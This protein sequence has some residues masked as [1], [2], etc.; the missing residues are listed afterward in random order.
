M[1]CH[2]MRT[3]HAPLKTLGIDTHQDRDQLA[4]LNENVQL[5]FIDPRQRW[6]RAT[7]QNL[8]NNR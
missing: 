4:E 8:E 6:A 1:G 7:H 5:R 2:F 3:A